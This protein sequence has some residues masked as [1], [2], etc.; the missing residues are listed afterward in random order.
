MMS[1]GKARTKP[2]M[3]PAAVISNGG[4][5]APAWSAIGS[6]IFYWSGG[7]MHVASIRING[8]QLSVVSRTELFDAGPFQA[9]WNR[10]FDVHPDGRTFVTVSRP[11][12]RVVWRT[13][14]LPP[15]P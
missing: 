15:E 13:R 8:E 5:R 14:A 3:G 2:A 9:E 1:N 11:N 12:T 7:R 4:G 6:E 10:S